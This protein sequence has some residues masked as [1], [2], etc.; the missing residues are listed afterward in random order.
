M[1]FQNTNDIIKKITLNIKQTIFLNNPK[2]IFFL[3]KNI[4]DGKSCRFKSILL[5]YL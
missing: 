3:Q 2:N 4:Y 1:R 5:Y